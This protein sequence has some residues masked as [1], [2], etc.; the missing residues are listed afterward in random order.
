MKYT[1][2]ASQREESGI[3][4]RS[5]R[6]LFGKLEK[7]GKSPRQSITG[8]DNRS[9]RMGYCASVDRLGSSRIQRQQIKTIDPFRGL[10]R[11]VKTNFRKTH[12]NTMKENTIF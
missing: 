7:L 9:S 11:T 12:R 2:L 5:I 8:R 3:K 4:G 6:G 10:S 1:H